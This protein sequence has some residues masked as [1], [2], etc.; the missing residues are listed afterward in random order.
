M[1]QIEANSHTNCFFASPLTEYRPSGDCRSHSCSGRR[2]MELQH[3]ESHHPPQDRRSFQ[4][5]S[6]QE[7]GRVEHEW[8]RRRGLGNPVGRGRASF[9]C[10]PTHFGKGLAGPAV[11]L[12]LS[13]LT[14]LASPQLYQ[15]SP[16]HC[17]QQ[18]RWMQQ[19]QERHQCARFSLPSFVNWIDRL[20][21]G[22]TSLSEPRALMCRLS[23]ATHP[24]Q[25]A[26]ESASTLDPI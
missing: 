8:P 16:A 19:E 25:R 13:H 7:G 23:T 5:T 18:L 4:T 2:R 20:T 3:L 11:E 15:S 6:Q 24:P 17:R 22:Q 26:V 1:A 10:R 9:W 21:N 12:A 14:T